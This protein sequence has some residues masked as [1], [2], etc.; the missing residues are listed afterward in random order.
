[1]F[2]LPSAETILDDANPEVQCSMVTLLEEEVLLRDEARR[3]L[4]ATDADH[5]FPSTHASTIGALYS[6]MKE[7][8]RYSSFY[9][10]MLMATGENSRLISV[11]VPKVLDRSFDGTTRCLDYMPLVTGMFPCEPFRTHT[12]YASLPEFALRFAVCVCEQ[13]DHIHG[14][15]N[16]SFV[17]RLLGLNRP[18]WFGNVLLIQIS[19]GNT[20]ITNFTLNEKELFAIEFAT[21]RI[22]LTCFHQSTNELLPIVPRLAMPRKTISE[23]ILRSRQSVSIDV[24]ALLFAVNTQLPVKVTTPSLPGST[25]LNIT[26]LVYGPWLS[27]N[28]SQV[29]GHVALEVRVDGVSWTVVHIRQHEIKLKALFKNATISTLVGLDW[30]GNVIVFKKRDYRYVGVGDTGDDFVL[31]HRA[32]LK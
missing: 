15:P 31:A 25:L 4:Q 21:R 3:R 5:Q 28:T 24:Q 11:L 26:D 30:L 23:W 12:L 13:S 9:L 17:N 6:A 8:R 2:V 27:G 22:L 1:M 18:G 7:S 20:D 14:F 32:V 10:A 29:P 19:Y 16:N